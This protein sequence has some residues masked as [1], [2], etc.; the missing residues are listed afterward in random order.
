MMASIPQGPS[1]AGADFAG[2]VRHGQ[3]VARLDNRR[4]QLDRADCERGQ[5]LEQDPRSARRPKPAETGQF[6]T[7]AGI[8]P[9]PHAD[10]CYAAAADKS[11]PTGATWHVHTAVAF[12]ME[13]EISK[14]PLA[15]SCGVP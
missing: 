9:R 2:G 13:N 12:E 1:R 3:P 15:I 5:C 11:L 7:L 4:E 8:A 10:G 14:I 6:P